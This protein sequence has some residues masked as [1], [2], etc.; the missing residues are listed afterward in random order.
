MDPH[1][2]TASL[3]A[4]TAVEIAADLAAGRTT[5]V[6]VTQA[7]LERIAAVDHSGPELRSVLALNPAALDDA[8]ALDAER[9]AGHL[10][11]PLHGVPVLVKDNIE[12][13]GLPASAGSLALAGREVVRDAPLVTA[14]RDA[15]LVVLGA[16]N[17][18]EWANMR[19]PHSTSGWSAVG[20]LTGNPWKLDRSAGGS[21][22]GSGAAIAAG[23]APLAIGTETDG[24]ITCPSSLNGCVGLKPTVGVV[25]TVGVVPLSGSQDSPGPMA[26]SVHDA[27]LLLS[28]L[29]GEPSYSDAPGTLTPGDLRLGVAA[30]WLSNH[31]GTD[32]LFAE[33]LRVLEGAGAML[34]PA[35]V[36]PVAGTGAAELTVLV[37]E[38]QED[39]GAYLAA[40][41]GEGPG[42]IGELVAFNA[43]HSEVE[44]AHFGQEFLEMAA[45]SEGRADPA[46]AEA[47]ARCLQWALEETLEPSFEGAEAP[48]FL[49]AP[50]YA[51][52]WKS[53]LRG[54]DHFLGGGL[55]SAAPSIA[56]WPVLCLPMGLV[57]GLPVGLVLV[58]R[59]HSEGRLLAAGHALEALLDLRGSLHPTW[60]PP[61]R[62]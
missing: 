60:L 49:V 32:A 38:L 17:L 5:S 29:T 23:L 15:G 19:S 47:R 24:S 51:P 10:R 1:P 4:A 56:G 48:E 52:A 33:V 40:R 28:A 43:K 13:L 57:E 35:D 30:G 46:Y 59:P 54:G 25:S 6:A 22:S 26:R 61:S 41:G 44:L 55:A 8:E 12:V 36:S 7:L 34:S 50:A 2:S 42:S 31:P 58:G 18:S 9:A 27:A 20:G 3:A 16:T 11:G 37:C 62:G 39:L 45:S 14:M 21:S 53:D